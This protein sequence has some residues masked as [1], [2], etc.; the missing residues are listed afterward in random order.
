M[1]GYLREG[2]CN[3]GVEKRVRTRP[4]KP[5]TGKRKA[6]KEE[7]PRSPKDMRAVTLRTESKKEIRRFLLAS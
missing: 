4:K 6:F 1:K 3:L 2:S 5:L 7:T